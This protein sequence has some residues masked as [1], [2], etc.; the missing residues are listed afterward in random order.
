MKSYQADAGTD[1]QIS[2]NH[3]QKNVFESNGVRK[4]GSIIMNP[5]DYFCKNNFQV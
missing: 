5:L 3:F 4:C 2:V 1:G